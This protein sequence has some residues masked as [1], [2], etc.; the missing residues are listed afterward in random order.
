MKTG[1]STIVSAVRD[2]E[3]A[4]L[5]ARTIAERD[6]RVVSGADLLRMALNEAGRARPDDE[7]GGGC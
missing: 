5:V 6:G 1:S 7:V 2:A 3:G 4:L